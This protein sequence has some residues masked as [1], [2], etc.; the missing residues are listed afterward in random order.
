ML[1]L[2]AVV[3]LIFWTVNN[4]RIVGASATQRL[5]PIYS[6]QHEDKIG[7][8][9]YRVV[10]AR[11][12]AAE[13][14]DRDSTLDDETKN[15]IKSNEQDFLE[16]LA[17]AGVKSISLDE[18]LKKIGYKETATIIDY[19]TDKTVQLQENGVGRQVVSPG[20]VAP[21]YVDGAESA[22][23]SDGAVAPKYGGTKSKAPVSPGVVSPVYDKE[24]KKAQKSP[25]VN[26]DYYSRKRGDKE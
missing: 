9:I 13:V 14:V 21:I 6:V 17:N 7:P 5:L 12:S 18:F 19:S 2:V 15:R 26:S 10:L 23:V 3:V 1:T 16:A 25:G 11:D 24:A 8:D 20:V 4:P 22:E